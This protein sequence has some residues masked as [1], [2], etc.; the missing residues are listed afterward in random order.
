WCCSRVRPLSAQADLSPSGRHVVG[1][2]RRPLENSEET[3]SFTAMT[4]YLP[5]AVPAHGSH[6]PLKVDRRGARR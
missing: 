4:L 6:E 2:S 5:R 3:I 1:I